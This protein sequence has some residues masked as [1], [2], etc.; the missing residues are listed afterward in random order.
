MPSDIAVKILI[1]NLVSKM[2]NHFVVKYTSHFTN[3]GDNIIKF[4]IEKTIFL[5][6]IRHSHVN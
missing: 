1:I 6:C 4:N 2:Y 5:L 3:F